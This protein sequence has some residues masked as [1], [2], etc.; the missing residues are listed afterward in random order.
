[1]VQA[2]IITIGD[3]LLIGQ[4]IDSNSAWMAQELNKAGIAILRRVAVGDSWNEIWKALDEESKYA[5][6]ILITGGLGPTSDDITKPLLCKYFNGKMIVNKEALANVKHIFENVLKR[7]M[8]ERNLKQA[9]VPDVCQVI[10]N[11]RGTAPGMWF[12]KQLPYLPEEALKESIDSKQIFVS[13]PGVPFEMQGMMEEHVIPELKK[14][15]VLP[16]ITHRTLLTAGIGE[17]FLAEQLKE[18]EASLPSHIKLAYLPNYGMVRLRLSTSGFNKELIEEEIQQEFKALQILVGDHLVTNEDEPLENVVAKL[19]LSK[20]KTV[21]TA[22]SCTGGYIA[23]LFTSIPG[24]S[25]FYN[26][27]VVS[28][29]NEVKEDVLQVGPHILQT[30][31]AVSEEVVIQMIPGVLNVIDSDYAIAVSG[32]MGPDGGTAEKPVGTVWITVGNKE[33]TVSQKFFFRFDRMRNI[34]LTAT[35][36]FNLLRKFILENG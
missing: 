30:K 34:Q 29:S 36:A 15:F 24:S 11:K 27:S 6:I 32:I 25:K 31:G 35:N 3:E 28:Y 4:V 21:T 20:N 13:M 8:I 14:Q 10:P 16:Y 33:R 23:H 12:E 7:P 1:M 9:E 22:E 18:F 5:Q 17:S 19:L 26:G 2:S